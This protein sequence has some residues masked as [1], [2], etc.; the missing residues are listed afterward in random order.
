MSTGQ[1]ANLLVF[2]LLTIDKELLMLQ[3]TDVELSL[4]IAHS[5]HLEAKKMECRGSRMA[6]D[7]CI[8]HLSALDK[9]QSEGRIEHALGLERLRVNTETIDDDGLLHGIRTSM[10]ELGD[11]YVLALSEQDDTHGDGNE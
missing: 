7:D 6:F 10:T 2:Q 1:Q 8:D 5:L 3:S 4:C 9:V 11:F